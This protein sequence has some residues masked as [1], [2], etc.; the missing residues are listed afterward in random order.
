MDSVFINLKILGQIKIGDKLYIDE[1]KNIHIDQV[2]WT[3]GL[4]RWW[5]NQDRLITMKGLSDSV[6]TTFSLIDS[7]LIENDSENCIDSNIK[8]TNSN[9]L[10][11]LCEVLT[12]SINGL[13]NLMITYNDDTTIVSTI[14][15][16]QTNINL[17]VQ[18]IRN[19]FS[20]YSK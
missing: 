19:R 14:Q 4:K 12:N 1:N 20:L 15:V 8:E 10:Q 9:I 17:R 11:R 13:N 3:Q 6:E 18:S 16:L 7:L 5:F 2:E